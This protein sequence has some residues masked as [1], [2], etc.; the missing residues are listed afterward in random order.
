MK[1][2]KLGYIINGYIIE[3]IAKTKQD[4][5]NSFLKLLSLLDFEDDNDIIASKVDERCVELYII[6]TS[7]DI[8][9]EFE[10]IFNTKTIDLTNF[11][12]F[13]ESG[14]NLC[15]VKFLKVMER[16][17]ELFDYELYFSYDDKEFGQISR[18]ISLVGLVD[19]KDHYK[20]LARSLVGNTKVMNFVLKSSLVDFKEV[21][22]KNK[23]YKLIDK[24]ED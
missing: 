22:H 7:E 5:I 4:K 21:I 8:K 17:F 12:N 11:R 16:F 24:I 15:N 6:K 1:E 20:E 10:R 19:D 9:K 13:I 14:S 2:Y 18:M 23:E 3:V